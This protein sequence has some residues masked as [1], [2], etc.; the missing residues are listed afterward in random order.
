MDLMDDYKPDTPYELSKIPGD[1]LT[2]P[3]NKKNKITN[4]L[5][6]A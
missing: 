3:P 1:R 2:A 5:A 6:R 4:P